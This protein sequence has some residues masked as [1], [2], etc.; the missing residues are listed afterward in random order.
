[1]TRAKRGALAF[2]V[3]ISI[4]LSAISLSIVLKLKSAS[5]YL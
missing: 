4:L 5:N 3:T 2:S 1:M